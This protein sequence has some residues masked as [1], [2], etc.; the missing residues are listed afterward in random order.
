MCVCVCVC[1]CIG[2]VSDLEHV[3]L[4]IH[5]LVISQVQGMYQVKLRSPRAE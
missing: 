3:C 1:V 4:Y 2:R 5:V